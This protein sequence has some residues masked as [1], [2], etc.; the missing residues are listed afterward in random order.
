MGT[1]A[2]QLQQLVL[3]P[4]RLLQQLQQPWHLLLQQLVLQPL[5][6]AHLLLQQLVLQLQ[7]GRVLQLAVSPLLLLLAL[8]PRVQHTCH[9]HG[10]LLLLV[11][12][13][14]VQQVLHRPHLLHHQQQQQPDGLVRLQPLLLQQL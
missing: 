1:V 3:Q 5:Q 7:G 4:V 9:G 13:V 12:L 8:W 10:G 11:L 14:L 2:Q 6:L